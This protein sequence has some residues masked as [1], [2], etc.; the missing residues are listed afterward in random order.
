MLKKFSQLDDSYWAHH[1]PDSETANQKFLSIHKKPGEYEVNGLKFI[2]PPNVYHPHEFGSSRFAL[3]GLFSQLPRWGTRI[4]E[5][6]AGSGV[7]G[8]CLAAAGFDVTLVDIDPVAVECARKNAALNAVPVTV[9]QSD[10]FSALGSEKFDLIFFNIPLL[11]KAIDDP[12]EIISC[13]PGGEIFARFMSGAKNYLSPNG[14]VCVSVSNIGSRDAFLKGLAGYDESIIFAEF[15]ASTN[16]WRWLL[17]A[18]P[19]E[20]T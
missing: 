17:A 9:H 14:H 18:Q 13:D 19:F 20:R 4:L 10:L 16:A 8:I 15:Y 12:L 6:G 7:V 3:R 11:D 5:L 2:C 1:C